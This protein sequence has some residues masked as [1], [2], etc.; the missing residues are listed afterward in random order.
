MARRAK[1]NRSP[2]FKAIVALTVRRLCELLGL[3][4]S[5]RYYRPATETA[6]NLEAMRRID[7]QY[8]ETPY[9]GSRRMAAA[10]RADGWRVN[11]KRVQRLMRAMGL[12][13]YFFTSVARIR[14]ASR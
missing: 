8:L 2:E 5:T 11:R 3:R 9:Y 10:L 6:A 14:T 13:A 1:M 4:R 7:A 12:V